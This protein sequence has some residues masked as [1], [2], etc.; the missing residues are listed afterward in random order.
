MSIAIFGRSREALLIDTC[1]G[2]TDISGAIQGLTDKPLMVIN[3]HGH[4]DH[5]S[6]NYRFGEIFLSQK[7]EELYRLHSRRDTIETILFQAVG[8]G[9][10]G[11]VA[12]LALRPSF[13]RS[14]RTR[15]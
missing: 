2:F 11:K 13:P 14:T 3:T 9:I 7:D 10:K 6:G 8:G 4:F 1:Y 12:I 15:S 5:I